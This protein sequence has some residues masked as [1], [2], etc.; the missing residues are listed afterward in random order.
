MTLL[1]QSSSTYYSPTLSTFVIK[2]ITPRTI[3]IK[4][5]V[6]E[7]LYDAINRNDFQMVRQCVLHTHIAIQVQHLTR[8]AHININ[9]SR[10]S[11]TALSTAIYHG[12]EHII[13][14]LLQY[15]ANVNQL[16]ADKQH[17]RI[18]SPL[19]TACRMGYT[20]IAQLLLQY[21]AHTHIADW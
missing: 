19:M 11:C 1:Q 8:N 17:S 10:L 20:R 9:S 2:A 16:S 18:E 12:N 6:L 4:L 13:E 7:H 5:S 21:G 14:H 15:G 3:Y